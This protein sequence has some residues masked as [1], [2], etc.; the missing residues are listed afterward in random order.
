PRVGVE[1]LVE[2]VGAA[3]RQGPQRVPAAAAQVVGQLVG[4]DGEQVR[5]Q[6]AAVVEVGQAVEGADERLLDHVLAGGAVA[7]PPLHE[8]QQPALVARDQGVPGAGVSLTDLLDQQA[9]AVGGH[10]GSRVGSRGRDRL[11]YNPAAAGGEGRRA[12]RAPDGRGGRGLDE[13]RG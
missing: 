1:L 5:L 9:V 8:G 4:G 2:Q 3:L 13:P 10:A 11:Y 7:Q 6:L 12:G